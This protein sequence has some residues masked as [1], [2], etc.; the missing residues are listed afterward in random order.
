MF[1][2][3]QCVWGGAFQGG[4]FGFIGGEKFGDGFCV[5]GCFMRGFDYAFEEE[6]EPFLPGAFGAN[7]IE[8]LIVVAAVFFEIEAEI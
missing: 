7:L 2:Y 3:A 4:D 8:Q 6:G 5:L 1:E